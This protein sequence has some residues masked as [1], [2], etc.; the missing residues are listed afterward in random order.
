MVPVTKTRTEKRTREVPARKKIATP[1][2]PANASFAYVSGKEITLEQI[3]AMA[4][5]D[6]ITILRL[7][8]G[9][10]LTELHRQT[11]KPD[12]IVMTVG[13][14]TDEPVEN[15]EPEE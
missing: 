9:Q 6:T 5:E 13:P 14:G 12:L 4:A 10:T 1:F 8:G 3:K 2:P 7:S 11:L 15:A